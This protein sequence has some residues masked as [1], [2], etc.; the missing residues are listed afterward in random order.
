MKRLNQNRNEAVANH[1]C[2]ITEVST[3]IVGIANQMVHHI[4]DGHRLQNGHCLQDGHRLED[5]HHRQNVGWVVQS[6]KAVA[7]HQCKIT[8]QMI[9]RE[10]HQRRDDRHHLQEDRAHTEGIVCVFLSKKHNAKQMLTVLFLFCSRSPPAKRRM[11]SPIRCIRSP[12]PPPSTS[13]QSVQIPER[14]SYTP[15][16]SPAKRTEKPVSIFISNQII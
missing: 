4:Q 10:V 12:T 11:H 3:M 6:N 16:K 1:Q 9:D 5:G 15:E 14:K 8:K 13:T 7:N 2:T